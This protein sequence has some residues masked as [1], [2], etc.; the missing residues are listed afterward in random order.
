MLLGGTGVGFMGSAGGGGGSGINAVDY[1]PSSFLTRTTAFSGAPAASSQFIFSAW[2]RRDVV[3]GSANANILSLENAG[4]T[5]F[6]SFNISPSNFV[7]IHSKAGGSEYRFATVA[8]FTTLGAWVHVL[9]SA[10]HNAA[11]GSRVSHLY[12]GSSSDKSVLSN[13]GTAFTVDM[14]TFTNQSVASRVGGS[15]DGALAEVYFAP[16]QFLDFSV[17]ANREKFIDGGSPVNLG[18]D[19]STPTG[20]APLIYLPNRAAT[21]NINAGTGGNFVINGAPTDASTTP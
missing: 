5:V 18:A 6:Y 19:G 1:D 11:T 14:T 21:V 20:V 17:T 15:F 7:S 16:G 13:T 3:H 12:I 9:A 8:T 4:A 10:Q 2:F